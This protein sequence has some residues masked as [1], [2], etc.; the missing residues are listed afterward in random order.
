MRRYRS[1][2]KCF[3]NLTEITQTECIFGD[4]WL[5]KE[6]KEMS[7]T[8]GTGG[9]GPAGRA[10]RQAL[11]EEYGRRTRSA[12][13]G[14]EKKAKAL[15]GAPSAHVQTLVWKALD[16]NGKL[17]EVLLP[18]ELVYYLKAM[19]RFIDEAKGGGL[20][21][22][23]KEFSL[24]AESTFPSLRRFIVTHAPGNSE[25]QDEGSEQ[26]GRAGGAFTA[27]SA[28]WAQGITGKSDPTQIT[29]RALVDIIR[30]GERYD[31][32]LLLSARLILQEHGERV[33]RALLREDDAWATKANRHL[34]PQFHTQLNT[35]F[36]EHPAS[37]QWNSRRIE[38][39]LESFPV[40]LNVSY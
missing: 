34:I 29:I 24:R 31:E 32:A 22:V 26:H 18:P 10:I 9:F 39:T 4:G 1:A 27:G 17:K 5:L 40:F 21:A 19:A 33:I 14:K 20:D 13:A 25:S 30:L 35:F 8:S 3:E 15:A 7:D 12:D 38:K 11:R 36:A 2:G 6:V 28:R 16:A 23:V 37:M